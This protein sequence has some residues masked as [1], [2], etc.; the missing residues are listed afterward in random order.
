M[1]EKNRLLME[2][3]DLAKKKEGKK[4]DLIRRAEIVHHVISSIRSI[5]LVS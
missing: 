1:L 4:Q 3:E 5:I 2:K